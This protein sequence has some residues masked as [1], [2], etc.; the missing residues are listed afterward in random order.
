MPALSSPTI[1]PSSIPEVLVHG[2]TAPAIYI[3]AVK[4]HCVRKGVRIKS[5]R[6]ETSAFL[7]N[8]LLTHQISKI[9]DSVL[10]MDM[11]ALG[12]CTSR[13]AEVFVEFLKSSLLQQNGA[14]TR[15]H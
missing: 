14:E 5:S 11:D 15:C 3:R 1:L 10:K 7:Q 2:L 9:M 13:R 8:V 12:I 6:V 4:V